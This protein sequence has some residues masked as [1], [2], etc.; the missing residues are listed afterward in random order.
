MEHELWYSVRTGGCRADSVETQPH[1]GMDSVTCGH[2]EAMRNGSQGR[3]DYEESELHTLDEGR[4]AV[5]AVGQS[6]KYVSEPPI[7]HAR[8]TRMRIWR[9]LQCN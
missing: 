3:P 1:V 2:G 5:A 6:Y 4:S 8:L 7:E 9:W